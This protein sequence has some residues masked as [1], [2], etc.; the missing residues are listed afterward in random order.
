[1]GRWS[2]WGQNNLD[3]IGHRH[4][5][6]I[7][8]RAVALPAIQAARSDRGWHEPFDCRG[9]DGALVGVGCTASNGAIG[10]SRTPCLTRRR[11][12]DG[13]T[14]AACCGWP[15]ATRTP[16]RYM[17][18]GT[19]RPYGRTNGRSPSGN[20]SPSNTALT[21]RRLSGLIAGRQYVPGRRSGRGRSRHLARVP[22]RHRSAQSR[23]QR[24]RHPRRPRR[25]DR[26][27]RAQSGQRR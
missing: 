12:H 9:R 24:Q 16:W 20:G 1:M 11:S 14:S 8:S 21:G 15:P 2:A 5:Y 22:A 6:R 7:R 18:N 26:R 25:R 27:Q 3:Q 23:H 10:L 17:P 4:H 19:V 13:P